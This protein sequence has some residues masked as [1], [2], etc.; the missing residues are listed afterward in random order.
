MDIILN[1]KV[2]HYFFLCMCICGCGDQRSTLGV[3]PQEVYSGSLIGRNSQTVPGWQ[4]S[5]PQ[6][7]SVYTF[8]ELAPQGCTTPSFT[9]V[10]GIELKALCLCT[11]HATD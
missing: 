5:G 10:L 2:V 4:A 6:G 8:P 11:N 9:W 1:V 7:L 3:I